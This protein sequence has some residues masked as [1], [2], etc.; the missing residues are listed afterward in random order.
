VDTTPE[1]SANY[2]LV[3]YAD[4]FVILVSGTRAL[5]GALLPEV[6]DALSTVGLR[7]S[8]EKTLITHIHKGL[9]K[10]RSRPAC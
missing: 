5:A 3:L 8:E 1:R 2:R 9:D 4:D 7:L 10:A 6:A